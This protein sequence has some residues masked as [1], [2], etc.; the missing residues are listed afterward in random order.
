[1]VT[2]RETTVK[3]WYSRGWRT[4]RKNMKPL[5]MGSVLVTGI[6]LLCTL[7]NSLVGGYWVIAAT[8]LFIVPILTVGW[9]FFCLKKV[10]GEV[11]RVSLVFSAFSR[12][13]KVWITYI[14]Y[15]LIVAAGTF[16]LIVPGIL[17][18]LKYG[19]SLL[20]VTDR[21]LVAR[22]AYRFSGAITRGYRGR[23]FVAL[24]AAAALNSVSIPFSMGL[25]KLGEGDAA[26]LLIFGALPMLAGILL[27]TPWLGPSFASAYEGLVAVQ[28]ESGG[29]SR[30]AEETPDE[31]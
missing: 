26:M 11:G 21:S 4:Y 22:H 24:L 12:Y 30:E 5:I 10:R 16:L 31:E 19:M 15:I 9:L 27:V 8:Q 29:T 23:L 20:A 18:A 7:F 28:E 25:Q 13:G 6:S 14:L 3:G 17:W 1:M 2:E